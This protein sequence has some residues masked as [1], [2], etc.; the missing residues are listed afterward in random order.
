MDRGKARSVHYLLV[1]GG[2]AYGVVID[3]QTGERSWDQDCYNSVM[4]VL[5][6]LHMFHGDDLRLVSGGA[7]GL[8]AL[9]GEI[10]DLLGIPRK[11]FPARWKEDGRSA[12]PKRNLRMLD[13]LESWTAKGHTVQV[14]AWP[15]GAGTAHC[16]SQAELRGFLVD[17]I[18]DDPD[19]GFRE[20]RELY[21]G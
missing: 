7:T 20:M 18:G 15:G 12:G 1:T 19:P 8:D 14:L 6:F 4:D 17:R 3:P 10:A 5:K 21:G 9:A 2:R 13:M 11:E 16:T